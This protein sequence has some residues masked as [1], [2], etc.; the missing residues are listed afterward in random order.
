MTDQHGAGLLS[1]GELLRSAQRRAADAVQRAR[2]VQAQAGAT[3]GRALNVTHM[4]TDPLKDLGLRAA[5]LAE[6]NLR[7]RFGGSDDSLSAEKER[8]RQQA[9]YRRLFAALCSGG[10]G[11]QAGSR[12]QQQQQQ[13]Q[14]QLLRGVPINDLE[15]AF[16]LAGLLV[17]RT[18]VGRLSYEADLDGNGVLDIGEF[19]TVMDRL[20]QYH[21]R[22]H[23]SSLTSSIQGSFLYG[24]EG[25]ALSARQVTWN[26]LTNPSF[27][28]AA[29]CVNFALALAIL[30][31]VACFVLST[32]A[33]LDAANHALYTNL[34]AVCVAA[35]ALEY[36]L[37]VLCAMP[38]LRAYL[39]SGDHLLEAL[40]LVPFLVDLVEEEKWR[41]NG[42]KEEPISSFLR[43]FRVL[44]LLKLTRFV[45]YV[46]LMTASAEASA[47]P[48]AMAGFVLMI[49]TLLLAF[50]AYFAERG[51]WDAARVAY[52]QPD[53]TPSL[54]QSIGESM[55]WAIITLTTVGYGDIVPATPWGLLAGA[56]TA[57]SGTIIVAFPVSIY[58]EEFAHEYS[59]LEKTKALQA[60][61]SQKSRE[62][63]LRERGAGSGAAAPPGSGSGTPPPPPHLVDMLLAAQAQKA[64]T[65]PLLQYP[66]TPALL[67]A[68]SPSVPG[69]LALL[70]RAERK[71]AALPASPGAGGG[72]AAAAA[73]AAAQPPPASLMASPSVIR[74]CSAL[75]AA[76]GSVRTPAPLPVLPLQRAL[77]LPAESLDP[78]FFASVWSL[79][80][81]KRSGGL[82]GGGSSSSAQDAWGLLTA[83]AEYHWQG[84]PN[85]A[86]EGAEEAGLLTPASA[87]GGP[88]SAAPKTARGI[89]AAAQTRQKELKREA[90]RALQRLQ[91]CT[92]GGGVE[93]GGACAAQE[94]LQGLAHE[95]AALQALLQQVAQ[96]AAAASEA[97]GGGGLSVEEEEEVAEAEAEHRLGGSRAGGAAGAGAGA[98]S[99]APAGGAG[100]AYK[101]RSD[102]LTEP[103]AEFEEPV[104]LEP[105]P[106]SPLR[107][108][109]A[110]AAPP[111]CTPAPHAQA[112]PPTQSFSFQR[113][114]LTAQSFSAV[115]LCK[116]EALTAAIVALLSE[117]RK[118]VWAAVRLLES[119]FRDDLSIELA[120]R[121]AVWMGMP[122]DYV[123]DV[124]A[125]LLC[126]PLCV[127]FWTRAHP[128]SSSHSSCTPPLPFFFFPSFLAA[129]CG[130]LCV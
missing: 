28:R 38:S 77:P 100:R 64:A 54:F 110:S 58:T 42:T 59:E 57:I 76:P 88:S 98:A 127:C 45:P 62:W 83:Q 18:E 73:A 119:R 46:S 34:E 112:P 44:R 55:Y 56:I 106:L 96:H 13:Q 113:T 2:A 107:P 104:P 30:V 68:L 52:V 24:T 93:A 27:S 69:N 102:T 92:A 123:A 74:D 78:L 3:L 37:K 116:D 20:A 26:T 72:R 118:R 105:V 36:T 61:M 114:C 31:A 67:S 71:A 50:A 86:D 21:D 130:A 109:R 29:L 32:D 80:A 79:E 9:R 115:D 53:G 117:N 12:Q 94:E 111:P 120:R 11:R 75:G 33:A 51:V 63:A 66:I 41:G 47:A 8:I 6:E 10:A 84:T 128:A 122:G 35:F 16:G 89:V 125:M 95:A 15:D 124:R 23:G 126:C 108:P 22:K 129:G 70:R 49:G 82:D 90:S 81:A 97:E 19:T 40:T 43:I 39:L 87:A 4:V 25:A 65:T 1:A 103:G 14:Q 99:P 121:W 60:E 5:R 48:M 7:R 17:A 101:A 91:A 85:S